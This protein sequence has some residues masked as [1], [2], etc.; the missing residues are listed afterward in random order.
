MADIVSRLS[1][2]PVT[3]VRLLNGLTVTDEI[4]WGAIADF[5]FCHGGT[6]QNKIGWVHEVN[7]IVHSNTRFL[8][9][10]AGKPPPIET[11]CIAEHLPYDLIRDDGTTGF[12]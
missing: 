12:T 10:T 2:V 5:Y 1:S 11:D 6:M 8:A 3:G 7:G 9:S 4:S